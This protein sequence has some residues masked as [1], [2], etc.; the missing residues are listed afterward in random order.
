MRL[1]LLALSWLVHALLVMASIALVA[2]KTPENTLP[3]AL[4]VSLLAT[5]LVTPLAHFWVLLIPGLV[6]LI[7]WSLIYLFAYGLGP[8]RAIAAGVVQA[9]LHFLVNQFVLG[10]RI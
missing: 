3:R 5:V 8:G 7:L 4:L 9:A 6:A 1:G 10:G 2:K